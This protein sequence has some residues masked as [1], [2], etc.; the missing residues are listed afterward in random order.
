[1]V[2]ANRKALSESVHDVMNLLL[3]TGKHEVA[4]VPIYQLI[5][6]S[7]GLRTLIKGPTSAERIS[8]M[9]QLVEVAAT[10]IWR[11]GRDLLDIKLYPEIDNVSVAIQSELYRID[12]NMQE[13]VHLTALHRPFSAD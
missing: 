2:A 11:E 8:Q 10:K 7:R 9:N 1:M 4:V 13:G 5:E 6:R 3:H 12:R